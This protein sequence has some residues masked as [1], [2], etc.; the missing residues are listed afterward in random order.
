M[1][2]YRRSYVFRLASDPVCYLWT[3]IGNLDTPGDDIDV[4]GARWTGASDLLSLP[5][6]K[7]LIN[8]AA[9]RVRFSL[10]GVS[11][12]SVRLALEDRDT[13]AGAALRLGYVEFDADWQLVGSI[14]WEWLGIA[15]VIVIGRSSDGNQASRTISL[16]VASADT[17]RSNSSLAFFTDADQR[18]R[19]AD[20]AFC[21]QVAGITYGRTRRFGAR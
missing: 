10:S 13:I 15:D 6:L 12:E 16:S 20:D 5:A 3:G 1:T 19:S 8:G 9:D 4:A 14:H 11:P 18:K 17:L 21:N 7:A 2:T